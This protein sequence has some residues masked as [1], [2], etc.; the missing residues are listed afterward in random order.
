MQKNTCGILKHQNLVQDD[1]PHY[2]FGL[3]WNWNTLS[4]QPLEFSKRWQLNHLYFW[5]SLYFGNYNTSCLI[6]YTRPPIDTLF[7]NQHIKFLVCKQTICVWCRHQ[8]QYVHLGGSIS[9]L[10]MWHQVLWTFRSRSLRR[11]GLELLQGFPNSPSGG[12]GLKM[13]MNKVTM[14]GSNKITL[15][16]QIQVFF[17]I[18]LRFA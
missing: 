14:A 1:F 11:V 6:V 7:V 17:S 13:V 12:G 3:G 10:A 16:K 5:L 8:W 2:T 18:L 15:L 4:H 9:F